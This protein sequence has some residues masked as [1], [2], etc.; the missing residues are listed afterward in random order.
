MPLLRAGFCNVSPKR[1]LLSHI[2]PD[3]IND[4]AD[5]DYHDGIFCLLLPIL[6]AEKHEQKS[7]DRDQGRQR[8]E[9]HLKWPRKIGP[10]LPQY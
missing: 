5:D 8:I 7:G 9:P 3:K 10:R 6:A 4:H 1:K 2:G